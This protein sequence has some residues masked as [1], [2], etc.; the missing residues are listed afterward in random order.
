MTIDNTTKTDVEPGDKF[1]RLVALY[2]IKGGKFWQ[3]VC[4]CGRETKASKWHLL[5]HRRKSC[6]CRI[7]ERQGK[8]VCRICGVSKDF[9]EY[10]ARLRRKTTL[11]A[12]ICKE[13]TR[14]RLGARSKEYRRERR[15]RALKKY[16]GDPPICACCG[17]TRIEFLHLD[18][19][20]KD[21]AKQRRE[22]KSLNIYRWLHRYNYPNVPLRVL[23][24]NCNLSI[25]AYGYC[26]HER[27]GSP[28]ASNLA[29]L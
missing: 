16:G 18:H 4:K 9:S 15:L 25:G 19:P 10:Y 13:C 26:P 12:R 11:H 22:L 17:E 24:A 23:C 7:K 20:N 28:R 27:E 1:G 2:P 14:R 6:G 21:G 8:L 3:C 5:K 29:Q